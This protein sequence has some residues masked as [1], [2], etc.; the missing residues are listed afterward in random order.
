ML[1]LLLF[2]DRF[3]PSTIIGTLLRIVSGAALYFALLVV[4][5]DTFFLE[6]A[7]IVINK[8]KK[9]IKRS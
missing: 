1:A 5:V 2:E 3:I 6:N 8:V 7:T 9:I 4:L